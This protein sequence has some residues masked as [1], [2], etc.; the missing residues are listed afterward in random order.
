MADFFFNLLMNFMNCPWVCTSWVYFLILKCSICGAIDRNGLMGSFY[1]FGLQFKRQG[2]KGLNW[3]VQQIALE[4]RAQLTRFESP[5]VWW[6]HTSHTPGLTLSHSP[7][8]P[9][10]GNAGPKKWGRVAR[11]KCLATLAPESDHN[12]CC[13]REKYKWKTH[14]EWTV[15][16]SIDIIWNSIEW[17]STGLGVF[18]LAKCEGE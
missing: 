17:A 7:T 13:S 6:K 4:N 8:P 2:Q 14:N 16:D 11:G 10:V 12:C 5:S 9:R 15:I 3:T 1:D 18:R